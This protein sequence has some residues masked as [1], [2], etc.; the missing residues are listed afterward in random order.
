[1]CANRRRRPPFQGNSVAP[2]ASHCV[3]L[4]CSPLFET[5]DM[6][7]SILSQPGPGPGWGGGYL[8]S[9]SS[10]CEQSSG[11]HVNVFDSILFPFHRVTTP[12][13]G[14][15]SHHSTGGRLKF[16]AATAGPE[17]GDS[18]GPGT[19]CSPCERLDFSASKSPQSIAFS[20]SLP[21]ACF[22][23][24]N[25]MLSLSLLLLLLRHYLFIVICLSNCY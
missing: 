23:L 6:A 12:P 9:L 18:R 19:K 15:W 25:C 22:F 21:S 5:L 10:A 7:Y 13:G 4:A 1:M 3:L 20:P 2:G 24:L 11:P 8:V 14:R 17:T 16:E